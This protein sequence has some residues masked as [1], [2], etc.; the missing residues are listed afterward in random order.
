MIESMDTSAPGFT[1]AEREA[2]AALVKATGPVA[3]MDVT[4]E[5]WP[6]TVASDSP[7][8]AWA[9]VCSPGCGS[10]SETCRNGCRYPHPVRARSQSRAAVHPRGMV[11]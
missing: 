5:T 2:L 7:Y 9:D 8:A 3:V 1:R 6:R 4:A 10:R 11:A